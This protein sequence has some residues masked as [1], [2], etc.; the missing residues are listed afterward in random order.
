VPSPHL[1][2]LTQPS[3]SSSSCT[4]CGKKTAKLFNLYS[5]S[6]IPLQ[7]FTV[8]HF[9]TSISL[10]LEAEQHRR[11]L[12]L[13]KARGQCNLSISDPT[14]IFACADMKDCRLIPT[15]SRTIRRKQDSNSNTFALR[16]WNHK[17]NYQYA[18]PHK[19]ALRI[20]V[21]IWFGNSHGGSLSEVIVCMRYRTLDIHWKYVNYAP[22]GWSFPWRQR[23][24]KGLK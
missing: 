3:S 1:T 12:C 13:V 20:L 14:L 19:T 15:Y 10:K 11:I 18:N 16:W 17:V 23:C 2:R 8:R 4:I 6:D 22:L 24:I 5:S 9:R 21:I 7:P